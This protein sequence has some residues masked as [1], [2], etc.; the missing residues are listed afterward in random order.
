MGNENEHLGGDLPQETMIAI[1]GN[2]KTHQDGNTGWVE[3]LGVMY[4]TPSQKDLEGDYF[5]EDT[6]YGHN[7]GNGASAT[8]NH[9]IPMYAKSTKADEAQVLESYARKQFKNPITTEQ[10]ELG[11]LARHALDL[12]DEYEAW[13]FEQTQNGTFKWS[14]GALAHLVERNDDGQIKR[15]EIGEFAY[16]PTPAEWRLPAIAPLK[17]FKAAFEADEI[18]ATDDDSPETAEE[19]ITPI[20][21]AVEDVETV[22]DEIKS[23]ESTGEIMTEQVKEAPAVDPVL[24]AVQGLSENIKAFGERIEALEAQ[25]VQDLGVAGKSVNVVEAESMG[26]DSYMKGLQRYIKSKGTE[27][28][29]K[30]LEAGTDSEGGYL[31]DEEWENAIA[32]KRES[33]SAVRRLLVSRRSTTSPIYRW[34]TEATAYAAATSTAEE[35]AYN[36]TDPAFGEATFTM[37]KYTRLTLVSEELF[38]DSIVNIQAELTEMLGRAHALAENATLVTRLEAATLT[39]LT[40]DNAASITAAE[41]PELYYLLPDGYEH[42]GWFMRKATEGLIRGLTGN[43]FLF[44]PTP[45]GG[46]QGQLWG[47]PVVTASAVDAVATT[48]NSIFGGDWTSGVGFV[49]RS[50]LSIS[51]NPYLYEANGQ[52]GIFSRS[53]W[54]IQVLQGEAIVEGVQA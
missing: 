34:P 12:H 16:T 14:S 23:T 21:D 1:G 18:N 27:K 36:Q 11:I 9:G 45:Q 8:L 53:R 49:E 6:F 25:P 31:V 26:S 2:L 37:T 3:G 24:A 4:G 48:N 28:N 29:I 39:S 52:V 44:V 5:T 22:A 17:T 30:A 43:D 41:I 47:S 13:V 38:N 10:T 7:A 51:I 33:M 54:D 35:A 50:G 20:V 40:L 32:K 46:V 42:N 15:W 19:T